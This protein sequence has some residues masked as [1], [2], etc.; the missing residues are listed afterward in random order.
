MTSKSWIKAQQ[1]WYEHGFKEKRDFKCEADPFKC[2]DEG[3]NCQCPNGFLHYGKKERSFQDSIQFN[4]IYR[5]T[6]LIGG[7]AECKNVLLGDPL[8]GIPKQ[9]W[10]EPWEQLPPFQVGVEGDKI[11]ATECPTGTPVYFGAHKDGTKV[12]DFDGMAKYGKY[13]FIKNQTADAPCSSQ[14]FG[15]DPLPGVQKQCFCDRYGYYNIT[16]Y[17]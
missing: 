6:P 16:Q 8:P 12:L 13:L 3:G 9:C 4:T 2:A 17:N 11:T 14:T 7:K 1:H 15:S 10:C 5:D